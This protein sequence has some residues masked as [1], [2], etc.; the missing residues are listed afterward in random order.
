MKKRNNYVS[1]SSSTSFV[2]LYHDES[3]F[4]FMK[5]EGAYYERFIKDLH[6]EK[7]EYYLTRAKDMFK[8][9]FEE[10]LLICKKYFETR[11]EKDFT[12]MIAKI[13]VSDKKLK[14]IIKRAIEIQ[15]D[16]NGDEDEFAGLRFQFGKT[17]V[18]KLD[19]SKD[20][21]KL[22][23]LEYSD[24]DGEFFCD[25]EHEFMPKIVKE[26]EKRGYYSVSVNHH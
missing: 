20:G 1:N 9:M 21:L 6:A 10:T 11:D 8:D 19:A 2:L 15:K 14:K 18:D 3:E 24:N 4:D 25:M 26:S 13:A 7:D 23:Y 17:L 12:T 5:T 16:W 22:V